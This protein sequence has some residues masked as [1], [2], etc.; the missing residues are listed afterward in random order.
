MFHFSKT[1]E[2]AV[3]TGFLVDEFKT[4]DKPTRYGKNNKYTYSDRPTAIGQGSERT[5][6]I[7]CAVQEAA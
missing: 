5:I 3:F 6:N 4:V 1:L 2:K 7:Y